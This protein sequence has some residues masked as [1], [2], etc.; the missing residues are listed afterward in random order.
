MV[1]ILDFGEGI[2]RSPARAFVRRHGRSTSRTIAAASVMRGNK[3]LF[4]GYDTAIAFWR[5][6]WLSCHKGFSPLRTRRIS[7][8]PPDVGLATEF[9]WFVRGEIGLPLHVA[10]AHADARRSM[11]GLTSH[12]CS[13][14]LPDWSFWKIGDDYFISSPE[15][16][17]VQIASSLSLPKLAAI[18]CEFCGTYA[19]DDREP[20]GFW[21]RDPLSDARRLRAFVFK[22]QGVRGASA[23]RKAA[24]FVVDGSAS[25]M[26][27]ALFLLLTLP[28][29]MGG[30][31]L[32]KPKLNHRID[33]GESSRKI[34]GKKH[35]V[36]D[37]FWEDARLAVEYD[38]DA[39]H[40][41]AD[42]IAS[43]SA[44]R[45]AL[46]GEGIVALTVT[47]SQLYSPKAFEEIA[48]QIARRTK[49]RIQRGSFDFTP[50]KRELRRE[51]L[52]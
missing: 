35:V 18:G 45:N 51:L 28:V 6:R 3:M 41:G 20:R 8:G 36:C 30:Y 52:P 4:L 12:V 13:G 33:L 50:A 11:R 21:T 39:F 26:E 42:R 14:S 5:S 43:D 38:S 44:R 25:P 24:G 7:S 10:V 23:A 16:S 29:S 27:M 47:R 22:C 17:F 31:G 19:L 2:A 46:L 40:A 15:L 34:C 48:R 49:K 1:A 9:A 37:L 32:A